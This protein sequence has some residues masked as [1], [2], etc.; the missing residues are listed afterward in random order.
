M[1]NPEYIKVVEELDAQ[2]ATRPLVLVLPIKDWLTYERVLKQF[3]NDHLGIV[4][5]EDSPVP[6]TYKGLPVIMKTN[7][8]KDLIK[9]LVARNAPVPGVQAPINSGGVKPM[10]KEERAMEQ[11]EQQRKADLIES[12]TDNPEWWNGDQV[13]TAAPVTPPANGGINANPTAPS[14]Q[15]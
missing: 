12:L 5:N 10:S 13:I 9:E 7:E 6:L 11:P 8:V 4:P 1:N 14:P 2:L 15:V 3:A